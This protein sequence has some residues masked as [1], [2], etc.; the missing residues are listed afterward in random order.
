[1]TATFSAVTPTPEIRRHDWVEYV[2]SNGEGQAE[3]DLVLVLPDA[4][5]V[6][7]VKL[8]GCRYGHE[9]LSGLYLPLAAHI[10]RRPVRG[11]QVCKALGR[12]TP[13][14]FISDPVAFVTDTAGDGAIATWHWPGR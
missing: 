3:P 12:D 10:W 14:P 2:D 7:E 9:Q 8:T 6:V 11:L 13:G 4:V 5:T 1:M